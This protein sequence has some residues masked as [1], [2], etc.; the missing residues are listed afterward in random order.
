MVTIYRP[1]PSKKNQLNNTLFLEEFSKL[2]EQLIIVPGNLL[3][4]GDF[5]YHVDNTT[6][7][8]TIKFN[9][10]LE[11]FNLQQH[12]NGPTHKRG[13]T[14]DLI[15]TRIGDRLVTN[16]EI[17]DPM[18]SDHLAV[19]CTLQ[20][21][22]PP[23]ERVEIKYR[24]LRNIDMDS[25]NNDLRNL[26]LRSDAKL[27]AIVDQYEK[28]LK[29]TLEKHAPI[30]RKTITL[31]PLAPW[32]NEEI[33]KAKRQRRRLERRWRSINM[34]QP[35]KSTMNLRSSM[36]GFLSVPPIRLVNYGQRSFS[37]AAPKLWNELPD[38]V[39]YSESLPVFK[40][41]LKTYLFKRA[42]K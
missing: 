29:E 23:L 38:T 31:R 27:P 34:L 10:I 17:H 15:M 40:T 9:K 35:L 1:P 42:Y 7:P 20:L 3:I 22:K 24:R 16:I 26:N 30:K 14:L 25:F 13:H 11:M 6:N 36:K 32:Y 18:L 28:T 21:E 5:N 41:R 12:V 8:E 4:V 39:R 33:G 37:H 2:M 19:S